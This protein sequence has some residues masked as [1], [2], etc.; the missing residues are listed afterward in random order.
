MFLVFWSFFESAST[1]KS[2][3][4]L[5]RSFWIVRYLTLTTRKDHRHISLK[6]PNVEFN[7]NVSVRHCLLS[8]HTLKSNSMFGTHLHAMIRT[9]HFDFDV[10]LCLISALMS[11]T[12][13]QSQIRHWVLS[14]ICV[15]KALK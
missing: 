13:H 9:H 8:T 1:F 6:V 5:C 11:K 14:L 7:F 10:R 4:S 15:H 12:Q 3:T 2:D